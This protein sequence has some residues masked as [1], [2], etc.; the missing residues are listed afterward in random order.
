MTY[1]DVVN[2]NMSHEITPQALKI[3]VVKDEDQKKNLADGQEQVK[4][5]L[6]RTELSWKFKQVTKNSGGDSV[7][8]HHLDGDDL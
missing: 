6:K 7:V 8:I 1:S 3:P 4:D 5:L 2:S